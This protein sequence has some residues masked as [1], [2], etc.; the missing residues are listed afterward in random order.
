M[1]VPIK[2]EDDYVVVQQE[3]AATRTAAGLYLPEGTADKPRAWKIVA[4]GANVQRYK[5]GDKIFYKTYSQD[6][7]DATI[8]KEEYKLVHQRDI[9]GQQTKEG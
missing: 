1:G 9:A 7:V 5:V 3:K 2:P 4:V 8:G 6:T